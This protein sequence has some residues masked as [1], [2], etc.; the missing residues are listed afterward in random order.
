MPHFVSMGAAVPQCDSASMRQ[1]LNATVPQCD[2]ASVRQ[3]LSAAVFVQL[4]TGAS[5]NQERISKVSDSR[6]KIGSYTER[7]YV[8]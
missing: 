4:T 6:L 3:C 7:E 5:C 8:L 2:S 1:C